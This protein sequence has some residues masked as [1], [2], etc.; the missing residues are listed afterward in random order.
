MVWF[1]QQGG[2]NL[3]AAASTT[4]PQNTGKKPGQQKRVR[5]KRTAPTS[6]N[7]PYT[8][9]LRNKGHN[10]DNEDEDLVFELKWLKK[11]S[12]KKLMYHLNSIDMGNSYKLED[13]AD[14][15]GKPKGNGVYKHIEQMLLR[16]C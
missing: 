14:T 12:V 8:D 15:L 6:R 10:T 5:N 9:R 16:I 1:H 13:M 7:G 11:Q 4:V 3:T 2:P